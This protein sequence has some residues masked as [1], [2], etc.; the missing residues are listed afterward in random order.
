MRWRMQRSV[1]I[2]SAVWLSLNAGCSR[3]APDSKPGA[4]GNEPS[5][6]G[7]TYVGAL[8]AADAAG[9]KL[10]MKVGAANTVSFQVEYIGKGETHTDGSWTLM[11]T[12]LF[13]YLDSP[14]DTLVFEMQGNALISRRWNRER[15]GTAGLG[16]LTRQ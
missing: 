15:Y 4:A 16:T 11:G 8:P 10:T 6:L 7:G 5:N 14:P 1:W 12:T 13:V 3:R 9:R 2:V